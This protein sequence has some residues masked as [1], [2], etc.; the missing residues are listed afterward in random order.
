M[1]III[2]TRRNF[3]ANVWVCDGGGEHS[4]PILPFL[5]PSLWGP[6]I[7]SCMWEVKQGSLSTGGCLSSSFPFPSLSRSMVAAWP[8]QR[9]LDAASQM[10]QQPFCSWI[11]PVCDHSPQ[12]LA[13]VCLAVCHSHQM[14]S[15]AWRKKSA[16]NIACFVVL[17]VITVNAWVVQKQRRKLL[18]QC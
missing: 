13:R 2:H 12:L 7:W 3:Q 14:L 4:L 15:P 18:L 8:Q 17:Q 16:F 11:W 6:G 9:L 1:G 5:W 10:K